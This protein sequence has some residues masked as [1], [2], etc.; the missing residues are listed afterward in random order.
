MKSEF[1]GSA[2]MQAPSVN[3]MTLGVLVSL[4]ITCP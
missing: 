1:A 4:Y 3:L 2:G